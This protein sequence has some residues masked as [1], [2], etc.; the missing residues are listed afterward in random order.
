MEKT[1]QL[2]SIRECSKITGIPYGYLRDAVK[3]AYPP[4]T[5]VRPGCKRPQVIAREVM[6]WIKEKGGIK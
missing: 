6:D 5:Y 2:V 4:P 3:S 1:E